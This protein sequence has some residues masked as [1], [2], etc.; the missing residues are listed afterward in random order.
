MGKVLLD[1]ILDIT[2]YELVLRCN[3]ENPSRVL[4]F[5]GSLDVY[6]SLVT[7]RV[8][9]KQQIF[10]CWR[11]LSPSTGVRL[12]WWYKLTYFPLY[13]HIPAIIKSFN[14]TAIYTS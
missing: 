14:A 2:I 10:P 12:T 3:W 7:I 6:K 13:F 8:D 1:P 5:Y 11:F 4:V 9:N